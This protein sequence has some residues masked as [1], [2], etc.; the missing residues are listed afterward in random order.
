MAKRKPAFGVLDNSKESFAELKTPKDTDK[1]KVNP[2]KLGDWLRAINT[3][4]SLRLTEE[5][6]QYYT[7]FIINR[8]MASYPDT[9]LIADEV[10]RFRHVTKQMQ[11]DFYKSFVPKRSRFSEWEREYQATEKDQLC[12]DYF[13]VSV[14]KARWYSSMIDSLPDSESIWTELK[15]RT[16]KGG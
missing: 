7:P 3:K 15:E 13:K 8:C 14:Q 12:I 11:F 6:E 2:V 4:T 10:N 16:T 5:N 1:K 9:V